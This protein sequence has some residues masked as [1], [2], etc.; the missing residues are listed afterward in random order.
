MDG[1]SIPSGITNQSVLRL[2][3]G[4]LAG[5]NPCNFSFEKLKNC[6]QLEKSG[7]LAVELRAEL[8]CK[9][10]GSEMPGTTITAS[11]IVR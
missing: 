7:E 1:K 11:R 10:V 5:G 4:D 8:S 9:D 2:S 3:G 6:S